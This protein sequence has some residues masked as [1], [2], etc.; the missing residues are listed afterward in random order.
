MEGGYGPPVSL[1]DQWAIPTVPGTEKSLL[2]HPLNR[3]GMPL[4]DESNKVLARDRSLRLKWFSTEELK[5]VVEREPE[6][7][8][9]CLSD[10]PSPLDGWLM[11]GI[12][13]AA[14]HR[15]WVTGTRRP[16]V[17][18]SGGVRRPARSAA[19]HRFPHM[20][21]AGFRN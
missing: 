4:P 7:R 1:E 11:S 13:Q 17:R 3:Q 21:H 6:A 20:S 12:W 5:E 9:Q 10:D 15:E 2:V 18:P 19:Q 16:S 8:R 14:L